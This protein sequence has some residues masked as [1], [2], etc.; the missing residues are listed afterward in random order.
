MATITDLE[1]VFAVDLNAITVVQQGDITAPAPL[2]LTD[3]QVTSTA[4]DKTVA[5]SAISTYSSPTAEGV[6]YTKIT[7]EDEVNNETLNRTAESLKDSVNTKL[8]LFSSSLNTGINRLRDETDSSISSLV[9]DINAKLVAL[10]TEQNGQVTDINSQVDS[11]IADLN[12]QLNTLRVKN[13][14]TSADVATQINN[15]SGELTVNIQK[16]KSVADDAQAKIAALDDVY[17][18]D[19]EAAARIALV[20]DLIATLNGADLGFVEAVDGVIDEVNGMNKVQTAQVTMATG[21]GTYAFNLASEGFGEFLA[22]SDFVVD[23]EAVDNAKVETHVVDKTA[24]GFSI[25]CKS[26]GVHF[27]PQP[28]DGS[29]TPV[30][31]SVKV[32]HSKRD[33]L[34]FNVDTLSTSFVTEGAT[35]TTNTVGSMSISKSDVSV[36]VGSSDTVVLQDVEGVITVTSTDAAVATVVYDA[37]SLTATISGV[38]TGTTEVYITDTVSTKVINVTVA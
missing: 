4:T 6:T 2:D 33:P 26:Q 38:A 31:I 30:N 25:V 10:K 13:L 32:T 23:V 3:I 11:L 12:G 36:S 8:S 16:V 15:I 24:T 22:T 18:T 14:E 7:T 27:V 28:I 37:P 9:G 19:T 20:N 35:T 1:T 5:A 21:N 29:V 17:K 34:T